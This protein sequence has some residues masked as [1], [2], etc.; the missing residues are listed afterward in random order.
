M[1]SVKSCQGFIS[2]ALVVQLSFR[3]I[4]RSIRSN[5]WAAPDDCCSTKGFPTGQ[6]LA[7][8][9]CA[10]CKL[11]KT[12]AESLHSECNSFA[13]DSHSID[14]GSCVFLS[15]VSPH[16]LHSQDSCFQAIFQRHNVLLPQS[17]APRPKPLWFC[18]SLPFFYPFILSWC[19]PQRR[20]LL[21]TSVLP[22]LLL[23][24]VVPSL[25]SLFLLFQ[26]FSLFPMPCNL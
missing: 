23:K 12:A 8:M 13:H 20:L 16:M 4:G 18:P 21:P 7:V 3:I 6:L 19:L 2:A 25:W 15:A 22:L 17:P 9:E 24:R 10:H 11:V 1:F 26:S 14:R 5:A